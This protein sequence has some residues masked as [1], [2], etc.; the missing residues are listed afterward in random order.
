MRLRRNEYCPVHK[1]LSCCG[2]KSVLKK[3]RLT[4]LGV[5]RIEDPLNPTQPQG[6]RELRSTAEM[7]EFLNRK[8]AG[9]ER[10][11][12]I[13]HGESAAKKT[14]LGYPFRPSIRAAARSGAVG[15]RN[16][17]GSDAVSRSILRTGVR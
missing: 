6:Y 2:R 16:G 9:Q 14:T 17:S 3:S 15:R 11:C 1:S 5:Q 13:C 10:K 12:A 7:R 8:I 4:R